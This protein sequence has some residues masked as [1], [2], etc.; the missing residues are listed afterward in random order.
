MQWLLFFFF[1][2]F[3]FFFLVLLF[4]FLPRTDS[5]VYNSKLKLWCEI[6]EREVWQWFLNLIYDEFWQNVFATVPNLAALWLG[7]ELRDFRSSFSM[8]ES[9]CFTR[10]ILNTRKPK[11]HT[12][13]FL[14]WKIRD[15]VNIKRTKK[16][17]HCGWEIWIQTWEYLTP[18][19]RHFCQECDRFR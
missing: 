12:T 1:F 4:T 5:G 16:W 18:I 7:H 6:W 14:F 2:F 8:C 9:Y 17:V 15:A 13:H 10:S 19:L 11:T 3:F